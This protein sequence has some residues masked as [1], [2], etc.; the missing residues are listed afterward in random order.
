MRQDKTRAR[1]QAQKLRAFMGKVEQE[2][3]GKGLQ[4]TTEAPY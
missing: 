2:K 3:L 4:L 1:T